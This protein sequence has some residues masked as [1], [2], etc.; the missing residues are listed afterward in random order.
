MVI[1]LM[2]HGDSNSNSVLVMDPSENGMK[3]INFLPAQ[4]ECILQRNSG[5]PESLFI[6]SIGLKLGN[7]L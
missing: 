7:L 3:F 6:P 4:M 2:N 5:V 1:L